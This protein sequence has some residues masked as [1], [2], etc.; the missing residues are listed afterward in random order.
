MDAATRYVVRLRHRFQDGQ[1]SCRSVL[2]NTPGV[3]VIGADNPNTVL[4]EATPDIAADLK[5]HLGDQFIVEPE[6]RYGP[7]RQALSRH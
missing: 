7:L 4:I 3:R 2:A 6:I 5:R 1:A